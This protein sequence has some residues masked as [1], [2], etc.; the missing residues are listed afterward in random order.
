MKGNCDIS[1]VERTVDWLKWGGIVAMDCFVFHSSR[2]WG[3][4]PWV[5]TV[6]ATQKSQSLCLLSTSHSR[7]SGF[8]W[9]TTLRNYPDH[10]DGSLYSSSVYSCHFLI[11]YDSVRSL[12]FLSF[13]V[14]ILAWNVPLI[15][16]IFLMRSLVFPIPL[17]S[18]NC[19]PLFLFTVHLRR[20]SYL[21]F[22]VS[23]TLHSV[24][25]VFL[26]YPLPFVSFL[27]I[28]AFSN[29]SFFG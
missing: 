20:A 3:P 25:Y 2:V 23:G 17:F 26:L 6:N 10:Y 22:L 1:E 19:F 7:M 29:F 15:S 14:P 21:S 12:S 24:V 28:F 27:N 4:A 16:P 8:R 9:V 13:I 18:S 5:F 11:F